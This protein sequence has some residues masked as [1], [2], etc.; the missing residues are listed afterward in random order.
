MILA[1]MSGVILFDFLLVC[2][3]GV[4]GEEV[5]GGGGGGL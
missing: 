2:F 4:L 1:L 5:G 3:L